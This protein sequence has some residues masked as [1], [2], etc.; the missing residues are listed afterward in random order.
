MFYLLYVFEIGEIWVFV[1]ISISAFNFANMWSN[2]IFKALFF[3]FN[4]HCEWIWQLARSY[5]V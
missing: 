1:A 3:S 5:K 4:I 2:G